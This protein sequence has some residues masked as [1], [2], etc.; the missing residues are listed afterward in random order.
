V[1]VCH[2]LTYVVDSLEW[3]RRLWPVTQA[4]SSHDEEGTHVVA[5][6]VSNST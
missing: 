2:T 4:P 6:P 5:E 3:K 1:C